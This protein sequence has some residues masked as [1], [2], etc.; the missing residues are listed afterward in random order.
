MRW[1]AGP[2]YG[3]KLD[4]LGMTYFPYHRATE[5]TGGNINDLFPSAPAS[6]GPS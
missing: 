3:R 5:I 2:Q 1:Y 6:E 4:A